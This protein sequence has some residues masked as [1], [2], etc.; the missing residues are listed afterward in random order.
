MDTLPLSPNGSVAIGCSSF[1]FQVRDGR[2]AYF[3]NLEAF[4]F[5]DSGDRSAMLLRIAKFAFAESGV[6]RVVLEA[7]IGVNRSTVRRAVKR[8]R[9]QGEAG[10]FAP[11]RRRGRSVLDAATVR[12]ADRLLA[13]G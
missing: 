1:S 4:D 12:E 11:R 3:S 6:R 10:F 13:R 9:S 7:A 2:T 5:H 8:L